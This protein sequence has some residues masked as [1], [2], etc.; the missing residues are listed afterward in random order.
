MGDIEALCPR[1]LVINHGRMHFD[2]PL[3]RLVEQAAPEKIVTATYSEA[4]STESLAGLDRQPSD[5]P[6]RVTV[7]AP[8]GT[9]AD[10]AIA[11]LRAGVVVDLAI[12]EVP[13][14]EIMRGIF[15]GM[16]SRE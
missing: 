9:V 4:P 16:R 7:R 8:R 14:E 13:V 15:A 12:E 3:A 6:T 1:V 2:G 10:V 11:L 5:S